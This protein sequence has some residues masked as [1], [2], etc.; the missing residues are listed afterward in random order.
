[1]FQFVSLLEP[2]WKIERIAFARMYG[3]RP[4]EIMENAR[5]G[6]HGGINMSE[7]TMTVSVAGKTGFGRSL[8]K[9]EDVEAFVGLKVKDL[10]DEEGYLKPAYYF[11][12][13]P[14]YDCLGQ[15]FQKP[16]YALLCGDTLDSNE[17][18]RVPY[19]D[20]T[21]YFSDIHTDSDKAAMKLY[22]DEVE[23]RMARGHVHFK[24]KVGRGAMHM[25]LL[26]GIKRDI[27]IAHLVR[28]IIGKD[29]RLMLDANNGYNYNITREVLTALRD[30]DIYWMEEAF[31]EDDVVYKKLKE[32]LNEE[33]MPTLIA[34]GE[35]GSRRARNIVAWAKAG[36]IDVLQPDIV[37]DGLTFWLKYARMLDADGIL[38]APH[39][40]GSMY[41]NYATVQVAPFIQHFTFAEWDEMTIEGYD[42]SQYK[43]AN[44]FV[45]VPNHPGFGI[46]LD[47]ALFEKRVA[48]EGWVAK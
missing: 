15:L 11:I 2:D 4:Q 37:W 18:I 7:A 43:L 48:A 1:M 9:K 24:L 40:F 39:N 3:R 25:P 33:G 14:L 36:Y 12:E 17:K 38:S 44:G 21:L 28:D 34:D 10:F 47:S 6:T 45:H 42:V 26:Q 8:G 41:G 29:A 22:R 27:D 19:Y 30:A 20:S 13:Y 23:Q 5:L 46:G 16:A 31:H 35:V 32:W